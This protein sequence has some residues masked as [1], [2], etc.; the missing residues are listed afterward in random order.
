M[1]RRASAFCAGL[2]LAFA[3]QAETVTAP[4]PAAEV[5]PLTLDAV[6]V[7]SRERYPQVLAAREKIRAQAGKLLSSQGAFD[8]YAESS[9]KSRL[10]IASARARAMRCRCPPDN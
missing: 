10:P 6:L 3:V 9:S 1:I 5:A 8:P 2:A 7:S 4:P